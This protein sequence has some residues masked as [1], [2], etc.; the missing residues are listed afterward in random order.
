MSL[1]RRSSSD[2]VVFFSFARCHVLWNFFGGGSCPIIS[3]FA[4]SCLFFLGEGAGHPI[5]GFVVFPF[6]SMVVCSA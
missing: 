6:F 3:D 2:V 4:V 5:C 1:R